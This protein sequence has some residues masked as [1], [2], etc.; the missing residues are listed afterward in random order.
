MKKY[1]LVIFLF[2][3][4]LRGQEKILTEAN[5][6]FLQNKFDAA[7]SLFEEYLSTNE[8]PGIYLKLGL[9]YQNLMKYDKALSV[10]EKA[11]ELKEND[12]DILLKFG[13]LYS[14]MG[15]FSKAVGALEKSVSIDSINIFARI[16]LAKL[17]VESKDFLEAET[18]Y[19][20]LLIIDSTNS[21]YYKQLGSVYQKLKREK[22]A[23][24]FYKKSFEL[25]TAD[26]GTASS[27]AL[28]YYNRD[29]VDSA[30]AVIDTSLQSF[31]DDTRLLKLKADILFSKKDYSG[32]VKAIVKIL[33][34]VNESPQLYQKLGI[35]YYEIAIEN[36]VG[37]AQRTKLE[38][39]M[40]TLECS[41]KND[42]TQS[43]TALYLG[44]VSKALSKNDEAI[45]YMEKAIK[46][47]YPRYTSAIFTNLALV[48]QEERNY[49]EAIKYFKEAQKFDLGNPNYWYY[50]AAIYD[51]Y[52]SDKQIPMLYY[53]KFL[54]S[55]DSLDQRLSIYAKDR[56]DELKEKIH[57]QNGRL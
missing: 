18:A 30:I 57:F 10:F 47:I 40:D 35:C 37:D 52:Y 39:A 14:S 51:S 44:L 11:N 41:F 15:Y 12:A 13:L 36:F 28:L 31:E 26:I 50:L 19:K 3:F 34:G 21:Y 6:L 24:E 48:N 29:R 38:S 49:S 53:Q 5:T 42:S 23:E 20:K 1:L 27:L 17:Y 55:G 16:S 8:D 32:A 54:A 56:I 33:A 43:L 45:S 4:S 46:L 9:C 22:A 2:M 7:A 25:N